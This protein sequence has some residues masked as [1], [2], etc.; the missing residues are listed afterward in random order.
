MHGQTQIKFTI[1]AVFCENCAEH[2][3]YSYTVWAKRRIFRRVHVIAKSPLLRYVRS[4]FSLS[5]FLS[6]WI[7]SAPIRR[8]SVKFATEDFYKNMWIKSEFGSNR[9]KK[10]SE[11][12]LKALKRFH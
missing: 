12:N 6:A 5:V 11:P 2:I 9:A 3:K 1:A 7:S 10:K 8:L 4:S